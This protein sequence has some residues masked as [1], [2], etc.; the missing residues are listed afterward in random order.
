VRFSV[1][2]SGSKGNSLVIDGGG[3]LVLVDVGFSPR[4]TRARLAPLG[5]DL[6]DLDAL[7]ITHGHGDHVKG[8]R[9]LAG[10]LA[11]P[12]WATEKTARFASTFTSLKNH[13]VVEPG[14]SFTIAGLTF[15]PI[16][17]AH[18]EPGSVAYVVHDGNHALGIC[19][20]L[21]T[22]SDAVGQAL[23]GTDS[24]L[25]EFN[26]DA[27]ML[28]HGPYP[29]HLRRRIASPLGHLKNED[30][31]RLLA[32]ARSTALTRVL[33]AHLSEVNNTPAK[34]LAHARAV[35][36][37]ADVDV[38]CAPQHAPTTWL[39]VRFRNEGQT[40]SQKSPAR[41]DVVDVVPLDDIDVPTNRAPPFVRTVAA[42]DADAGTARCL[43]H[44]KLPPLDPSPGS[45]VE[46][47]AAAS[48]EGTE[49]GA[50]G[51]TDQRRDGAT[52]SPLTPASSPPSTS[53]STPHTSKSELPR[54][55]QRQVALFSAAP[56]LDARAPRPSRSPVPEKSS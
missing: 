21:G 55:L 14:V 25:L 37:G 30:G 3:A 54:A 39:R 2:G 35:V 26:H 36:D 43:V 33:C 50:Q 49:A 41:G 5:I 4:E 40:K 10:T 20:D 46:P 34:A 13:R 28:A 23:H 31:A 47:E 29:A 8:A 42:N 24:L 12:T 44:S 52:F 56:S 17:T 15:S 22:P 53:T 9:S 6:K 48:A 32:L 27:H 38:A 7:V 11:L 1:L 19:T 51:D 45:R 18:D 16:K